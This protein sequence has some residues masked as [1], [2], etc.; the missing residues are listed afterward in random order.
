MSADNISSKF[1]YPTLTKVHG[2][3]NYQS[4]KILKDE[5]KTNASCIYLDLGGGAHGHL[6]L[7][8]TS[9][10]YAR[11]SVVPYQHHIHPGTLVIPNR[12][13][14]TWANIMRAKH[15]ELK[16]LFKE[17]VDLEKILTKQLVQAILEPYMKQF[18]NCHSNAIGERIPQIFEQRFTSY[19]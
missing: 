15:K 12:T 16:K 19:G 17:M 18:C 7:V 5:V 14:L 10:E 8:L 3:L 4:L 9:Q 13:S 2:I 11:V 6:G 1:K